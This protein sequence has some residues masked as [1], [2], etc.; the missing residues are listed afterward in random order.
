MENTLI[1]FKK[2]QLYL[3]LGVGG[4]TMS[5]AVLSWIFGHNQLVGLFGIGLIWMGIGLHKYFFGYIAVGNDFLK[6]YDAP[7]S[8]TIRFS[9]INEIKYFAGDWI[10]KY[11]RDKEAYVNPNWVDA[12]SLPV[13][14]NF[15]ETLQVTSKLQNSPSE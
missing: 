7:L 13:L 14:R 2:S 6:I 9:E 15:I 1:R 12:R 4:L 8:K 5:C 10:I 11:N 3:N